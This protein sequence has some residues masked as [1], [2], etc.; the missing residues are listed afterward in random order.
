MTHPTGMET[1][2]P[3]GEFDLPWNK[4]VKIENVEFEGGVRLL[5]LRFKEGKRFTIVDV[6]HGNAA[7]IAEILNRWCDE[8][9]P[10]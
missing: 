1:V 10:I 8:E 6:D 2:T 3:L 7:R 5:R 9:A 4:Q